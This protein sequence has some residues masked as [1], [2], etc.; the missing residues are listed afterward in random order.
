MK[1]LICLAF[2]FSFVS[3][4]FTQKTCAQSALQSIVDTERAFARMSEENGTRPAFMAFIAEDGILFRPRAVKGKQ[5]M[6]EH[7]LPPSEKRPLLSWQPAF[8]DVARSGDMGYTTGPWEYKADIHDATPVAWGN[9]LTV[10]KK[11]PD[12]TW[13]FAIDL[14]I[15]NPQP[16]QPPITWQPP[17]NFKPAVAGRSINV[18]SETAA[19]LAREREFSKTSAASGA[20]KAFETYAS[21]EV[22]MFRNDKLPFLGK[23]TAAAALPPSSTVWTWQPDFGDVSQAGDLGYSYGTYWLRSNDATPKTLET[24]NY[25]RIWKK[26]GNKWKVVA[27]LIDPVAP[28]PKKN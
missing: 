7:P 10:W 28:E 16:A 25:Y 19:L 15:S 26:Q 11:Q 17:K 1:R 4:G 23:T 5:W 14:G 3:F 12:G 9:F 22:R 27:D 24:G 13:K 21:D 18:N 20:Q 6:T 2:V 8:A